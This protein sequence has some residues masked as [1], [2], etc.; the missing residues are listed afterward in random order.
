MKIKVT[1][2]D[3]AQNGLRVL[4]VFHYFGLADFQAGVDRENGFPIE[5]L[6]APEIIVNHPFVDLRGLDNL[7]H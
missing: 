7:V 5:I 3:S 1:L 2:D 4:G 6:L